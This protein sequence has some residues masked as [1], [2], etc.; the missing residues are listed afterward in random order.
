MFW[1]IKIYCSESIDTHRCWNLIVHVLPQEPKHES[2]EAKMYKNMKIK[3]YSTRSTV[4][5]GTISSEG[6]R[7]KEN[8]PQ[9]GLWIICGQT[10][11]CL[12]KERHIALAKVDSVGL[13]NR[14]DRT[15]RHECEWYFEFASE[16]CQ[17]RIK[18]NCPW[19]QSFG[20]VVGGLITS[21]TDKSLSMDL[22][23]KGRVHTFWTY[24]SGALNHAG[25]AWSRSGFNLSF[26]IYL[27]NITVFYFLNSCLWCFV[28]VFLHY[29]AFS[30]VQLVVLSKVHLKD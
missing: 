10:I 23:S 16:F 19:V 21:A 17:W 1:N 3:L 2:Y 15:V 30:S 4:F 12:W 24:S 25:V 20:E 9:W 5:V 13:V 29:T 11:R 14:S 26:L 8:G 22:N 27:T 6:S 7:S 28:V 18:S